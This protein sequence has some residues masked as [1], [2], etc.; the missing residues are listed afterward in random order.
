[1]RITVS[2][3]VSM[4]GCM[5]DRSP[6]RLILSSAGDW[7]Q[8]HELRA[9]C[10]A[11]MVGAGTLRADDPSLTIKDEALRR[12][13]VERGQPADILRVSVNGAG[14]PLD[15]SLRFFTGPGRPVLFLN[16][17]DAAL[18]EVADTVV[19]K[20]ITA[21]AIVAHLQSLGVKRLMV[22]GGPQTL[23]MFFEEGLVDELRYAVAPFMVNDPGAPRFV[24]TSGRALHG[25]IVGGVSQPGGDMV[26]TDYINS[27]RYFLRMAIEES[28]L[29][30]PV[31]TSYRVGA[32]IKTVSGNIYKGY[33]HQTAPG[34][35]AEEEAIARA[36]ASGEDLRGA[37]IHCSMEP[38]SSR[39]SKPVPC[40]ELI[41][42]HGISRV[43]YAMNEPDHFVKCRS[44]SM[45]LH[46]G[47]EV[48]VFDD[49][50][51]E[52]RAINAH[53]LG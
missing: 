32:I 13:R 44:H 30:P 31:E 45:L 27:D 8:V 9:Q 29:S 21:R 46:K 10:D 11:I 39:R 2:V 17:P 5:D 24:G 23:S 50:S 12:E 14:E 6:G 4:D 33:T 36:L 15:P 20:R 53:I 34:N 41:L 26:V 52:V 37:A 38:C 19:I 42:R 25:F 16:A 43:I 40:S 47:V 3:A 51:P 28:K 18:E 22:E 48:K 49:L 1:M 35:H 7:R